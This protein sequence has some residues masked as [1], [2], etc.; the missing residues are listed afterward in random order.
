MDKGEDFAHLIVDE[1]VTLQERPQRYQ[2]AVNS[3]LKI[4]PIQTMMCGAEEMSNQFQS[5][6]KQQQ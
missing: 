4:T 5:N 1:G 6:H 2:A 3:E